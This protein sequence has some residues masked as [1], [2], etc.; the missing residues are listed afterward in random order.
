MSELRA[1]EWLK[2]GET[3]FLLGVHEGDVVDFLSDTP[4]FVVSGGTDVLPASGT[5]EANGALVEGV[6][7][8]GNGI[9]E[10]IRFD[11][12]ERPATHF[13]AASSQSL[14]N[15]T[16]ADFLM[17]D[18]DFSISAWVYLDTVGADRAV[19]G[20]WDTATA[21][22]QS[23]RLFYNSAGTCFT[24]SV[25]NPA[26]VIVSVSTAAVVAGQWYF[27]V[28]LHDEAGDTISISLDNAAL[29]T[30]AFVN[31][32][33][34][35]GPTTTPLR[36]GAVS[37]S[38]A[39][40]AFMNG[41]IQSVGFWKGDN[42]GS[43]TES[44]RLLA[45]QRT[46][47][48]HDGDGL[49]YSQ[50]SSYLKTYLIEWWDLTETSGPRVGSH[51]GIILSPLN[52]PTS[53]AGIPAVPVIAQ[54]M[55]PKVD[56][57]PT[58]TVGSAGSVSPQGLIS[59]RVSFINADGRYGEAGP[60]ATITLS[61]NNKIGLSNIPLGP[62]DQDVMG[63]AIWRKDSDM[64]TWQLAFTIGDNTTTSVEDTTHYSQLSDTLVEG[65]A[66][67]PPCRYFC[68]WQ[69]R[70]VGSGNQLDKSTLYI[71]NENEP[72]Y[73]PEIPDDTDPTQGARETLQGR[74]AAEI[75]GHA[76]HGGVV[77]AFTG[78]SG[79]L[80]RGD[81]PMNFLIQQFTG[82]G[83][84]SHRSIVSARNQLI[85]LSDDGV[86][87]WAQGGA[88]E[89]ISDDVRETLEALTSA[90]LAGAHASLFQDRYYLFWATGALVFDL[91]YRVWTQ[92]T[93]HEWHNSA[94]AEFVSSDRQRMW[95]AEEGQPR[96][97]ELETG[98][99]DDLPAAGTAI[100]ATWA[101]RDMDMGLPG[102]DKRAH[103]VELKFRKVSAPV[104]AVVSIYRGTG[105]L[106]QREV[107]NIGQ[108]DRPGA[109]VSRVFRP[110]VEECRDENLRIQVEVESAVATTVELLSAGIMYSV[111]S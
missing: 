99:T 84:S 61:T 86:Y 23:W 54:A 102:R 91:H 47:L 64:T 52:T 78:G 88:V 66:A 28:C 33:R 82:H 106:V 105:E 6:F 65:N 38:G 3:E 12:L 7:I 5:A 98:I 104:S 4:G 100:A 42:V 73:C 48:Y 30:S 85:W 74:A 97:Y 69:N 107:V 44:G 77:A 94:V 15:S 22:S 108:S 62:D 59:Y 45:A 80:L 110:L 31:G 76:T 75:I 56:G 87:A 90:E 46:A 58:L 10:N 79:W 34:A 111:A 14:V 41:R 93:N 70:L 16:A 11:G 43:S 95:A 67:F 96:V 2:Q 89:R 71:S 19:I 21:A 72:W 26:G 60:E 50:L 13:T 92:Y 35:I 39:P 20:I 8:I 37:T 83:A 57:R 40:A 109:E 17:S 81:Q 53:A 103:Y 32:P 36:V 51:Q 29:V 55:V 25:S 9:D 27:L 1:L 24:F 68:E 63:R 101:S 18:V 49:F